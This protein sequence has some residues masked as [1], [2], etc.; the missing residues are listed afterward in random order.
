MD[1]IFTLNLDITHLLHTRIYLTD[2]GVDAGDVSSKDTLPN[3]LAA[4]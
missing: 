2:G 1:A 3:C 4:I